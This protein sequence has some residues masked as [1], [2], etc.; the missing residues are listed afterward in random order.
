MYSY[1]LMHVSRTVYK[2]TKASVY[3]YNSVSIVTGECGVLVNY[4]HAVNPINSVIVTK[5]TSCTSLVHPRVH[6]L[7]N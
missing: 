1:L 4:T 3:M 5:I 2:W 7:M 6:G